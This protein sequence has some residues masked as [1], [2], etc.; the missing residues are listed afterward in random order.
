MWFWGTR[1]LPKKISVTQTHSQHTHT[2]SYPRHTHKAKGN[3]EIGDN[4]T[5]TQGKAMPREGNRG[6]L[7]PQ[8][9]LERANTSPVLFKLLSWVSVSVSE[10]KRILT[11]KPKMFI[12]QEDS[13]PH[14]TI[15]GGWRGILEWCSGE[16]WLGDCHSLEHS[17]IYISYMWVVPPGVVQCEIWR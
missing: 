7:C 16:Y 5:N 15:S 4:V 14:C 3:P 12:S 8:N 6:Q 2:P 13:I 17:P 10:T 9:A 1:G 11:P